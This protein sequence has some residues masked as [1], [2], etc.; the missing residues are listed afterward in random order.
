MRQKQTNR[1]DFLKYTAAGSVGFWV[2]GRASAAD[3][4][5]SKS[6]NE[7]INVASVGI[8]GKGDSDSDQAAK[9][10]NLIAICDIDDKRLNSKSQRY[11]K[12]G[13]FNDFREMFDKLGKEID[14]VTI[15]TPDFT[16]AVATMMAIKM[17]K[18]VYTQKPLTHDVFEARQLRL[19]AREYK[20]MSQM[21]N[22]GTA[23]SG[24]RK[25][26]EVIQ[27]GTIGPVTEAH[28][29][30]NRPT[31]W[32][33]QS[34]DIREMP[35]EAPIPDYV[36][37]DLWNGTA[38][39]RP[40][41]A[42]YY[43]PHNWRGWWDFGCGALGDMGCHTAN[44]PFMALK[45]GYP[46]SIVAASEEL[47]SQTYPGWAHVIFEFPARGA[48]PA[49]KLN[50]YEG[51][52]D[53]K[54][55]QPPQDLIEK[56]E[57]EYNQ[58]LVRNND[59]RVKDGKKISLDK[60]GS[61]MVG[62]KGILYSPGDYGNHWELLPAEQ[63]AGYKAPAQT[64]AR[65]A[66]EVAGGSEDEANKVEWLAAIKGGPPPMSNFDYSGMLAETILLGNVAIRAGGTMLEWDG[67]NMKFPNAPQ[68]EKFLKR[69]YRE[70]WS[71]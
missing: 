9:H 14:A 23:T 30:T 68:A 60:G 28:V 46:S 25:G 66:F 42:K 65:N 59:K 34:P 40:Y 64:I 52:K 5:A 36:H 41:A 51:H 48:M 54:L 19:A 10:A 13:K 38:P 6:P 7:R 26:V 2:A 29:W 24:L 61:I 63:F 20:I 69:N 1:R 67:P 17:G 31:G 44:L 43:H 57:T 47:N 33:P 27:A 70:P 50:W 56:V 32:W 71:L 18:H 37:W 16:H 49:M 3:E 45:L 21:G 35:P 4:L 55:V 11:P 8:G 12:A 15:S 39:K 53:G 62:E 22:Q 58:I